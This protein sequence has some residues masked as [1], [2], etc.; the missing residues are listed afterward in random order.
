MAAVG[1]FLLTVF[2]ASLLAG[3]LP[4]GLSPPDFWFLFVAALTPRVRPALAL[5]LA[6]GVGLF[7]DLAGGGYLGLMAVGLLMAAYAILGLSTWLHPEEI[8]GRAAILAGA[9]L[10]KWFGVFLVVYVLGLF[11]VGPLDFAG[12]ILGEAL[13]T[14]LAAPFYLRLAEAILGDADHAG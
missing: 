2:L 5:V 11:L 10:A 9:S 12:A 14:A 13:L 7:A 8:L 4:D 6:F 3:L 1:L